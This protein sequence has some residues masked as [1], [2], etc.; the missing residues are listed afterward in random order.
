MTVLKE[1]NEKVYKIIGAC[2]EVHRNLGRVGQITRYADQESGPWIA[3]QSAGC[4]CGN[5]HPRDGDVRFAEVSYPGI[6]S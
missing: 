2:M 5:R 1:V 4:V 6:S 3:F